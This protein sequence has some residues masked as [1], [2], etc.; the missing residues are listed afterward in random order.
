MAAIESTIVAATIDKLRNAHPGAKGEQ[1]VLLLRL[2]LFAQTMPRIARTGFC[3]VSRI[4]GVRGNDPAGIWIGT[5]C[6]K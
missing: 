6:P 4:G 3:G 2:M 5:Y 1:G